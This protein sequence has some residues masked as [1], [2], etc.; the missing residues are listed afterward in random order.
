M[1]Y[2][3]IKDYYKLGLFTDEDLETF[4]SVGWITDEQK[5][6]IVSE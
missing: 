6:T 2:E 5:K 1:N 3:L 4:M